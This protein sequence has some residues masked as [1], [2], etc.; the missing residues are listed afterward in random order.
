MTAG[1]ASGGMEDF[2]DTSPLTQA[3]RGEGA[4][5][6]GRRAVVALSAWVFDCCLVGHGVVANVALRGGAQVQCTFRVTC[7]MAASA[8]PILRCCTVGS[9]HPKSGSENAGRKHFRVS[10]D[11]QPWAPHKSGSN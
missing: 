3:G 9:V 5:R 4:A 7:E 6:A 10:A 2:S 8:E 1:L 11:L